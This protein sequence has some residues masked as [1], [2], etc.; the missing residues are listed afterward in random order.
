MMMAV[1]EGVS[2][3]LLS[4]AKCVMWNKVD[5]LPGHA[6]AFKLRSHR[7]SLIHFPNFWNGKDHL[8]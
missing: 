8:V 3:V 1:W 7:D 2:P 6:K 4:V 5:V